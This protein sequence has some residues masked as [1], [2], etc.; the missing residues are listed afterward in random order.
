MSEQRGKVI[1]SV[2]RL[3]RQLDQARET[4]N[5]ALAEA[6]HQ[7]VAA[8]TKQSTLN[9]QIRQYRALYD[10]LSAQERA[11]LNGG[12]A[13]FAPTGITQRFIAGEPMKP[14]TCRP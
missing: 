6:H 3:K 14:A 4:A 9:K 12:G 2:L 11:Q 13:P 1:G 10:K 7:Y 5:T 8:R